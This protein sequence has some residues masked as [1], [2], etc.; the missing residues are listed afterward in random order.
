MSPQNQARAIFR[1]VRGNT[2]AITVQREAFAALAASITSTNGGIQLTSGTENGQ[3]FTA[4]H[5]SNAQERFQVLSI[6]MAMLDRD[7]SGTTQTLGRF[8]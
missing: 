4:K 8:R 5:S 6:L 2:A 1:A 7:Y 3:S